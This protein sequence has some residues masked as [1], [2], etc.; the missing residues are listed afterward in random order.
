MVLAASIL[1][2]LTGLVLAL[3]YVRRLAT[4][5]MGF[6]A[7]L[8]ALM[9]TRQTLTLARGIEAHGWVR[10]GMADWTELP[11]LLVSV[12]AVA[13][14]LAL[15]RLVVRERR[16]AQT[17]AEQSRALSQSQKLEVVGRIAGGIAHDFNNLLTVILFNL[18]SLSQQVGADP[19]A[20]E[21]V[22]DIR[23]AAERGRQ[24]TRRLL[25]LA[26]RDALQPRPVDLSRVVQQM[27]PLMRRAVPSRIE[28]H[29]SRAGERWVVHADPVQVE[30]V[31]LNLVINAAD[32]ISETGR[33]DVVVAE[34]ERDG[35]RHVT[36]SV[37]D[38]GC[39]MSP[40][41]QA[42]AFDAF[43]STK[44]VGTGTGLGL[45][46]CR[47]IVAALGGTIEVESAPGRGS[48]FTVWLPA[49]EAEVE[50]A[51]AEDD[52]PLPRGSE[53][54]LVAEDESGVR[55]LMVRTLGALGYRVLAAV[56][57]VAAL[58]QVEAHGGEIDL[59]VTDVVMPRL[60][61]Q[62]LVEALEARR[63]GLPVLVISGY[64]EG[65]IDVLEW[66]PEGA[67][68]PK[69]FSGAELA[70]RV[71]QALDRAGT[72]SEAPRSGA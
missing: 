57:G 8:L 23:L 66:V 46:T 4:W 64:P 6:M 13:A 11:G 63:P 65:S 22:A 35:A 5:R 12:L 27:A 43:F 54:V 44:P 61:G 37:R 26:R 71:R 45:S 50:E 69:P 55:E 49:T 16:D 70:H 19:A 9:A 7:G 14:L 32:A 67:F 38:D 17:L 41:V 56:D 52:E 60:G 58:Q 47:Q 2:R 34:G 51:A 28:L 39:G 30:Q 68:L 24:L 31:L 62:A 25:T 29:L 40:E 53:T 72:A 3:W 48:T 36:L 33:I 1:L 18:E 21:M 15:A 42:R 10:L 20:Q 59:V